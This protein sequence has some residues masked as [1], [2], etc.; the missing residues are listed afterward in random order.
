MTPENPGGDDREDQ[1]LSLFIRW[2]RSGLEVYGEWARNDHSWNFRDFFIQPEHS[3]GYVLGLRKATLL[4][5]RRLLALG[6]ELINLQ[7]G[8]T[9]DLRATPPFYSHH[10][11]RQGYTNQGQIIGSNV[12]PGGNAQV[13]TTEL[14]DSWGRARLLLE[15]RIHDNDA[16][17]EFAATH[18]LDSC[19]HHVGLTAGFDALVF[20]GPFDVGGGATLTRELNRY[21]VRGND[22]WNLNLRLSAR[23]R[24]R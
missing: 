4:N 11:V 15:R 22:V 17:F 13:I 3:H 1:P 23:W 21:F 16:Y 7:R 18:D 19:C 8:R 2:V 5:E 14:Y 20:T 10:I 12:G 24:P 9:A 6:A